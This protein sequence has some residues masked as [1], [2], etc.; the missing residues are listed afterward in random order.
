MFTRCDPDLMVDTPTSNGRTAPTGTIVAPRLTSR[1][2][3]T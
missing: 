2:H 1:H 3:L